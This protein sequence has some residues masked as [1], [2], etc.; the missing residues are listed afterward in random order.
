MLT[1][2][3]I[4]TFRDVY[5]NQ[6]VP[7]NGTEKISDS[8][9]RKIT[10]F[11]ENS[12]FPC[13]DQKAVLLK[14]E[15]LKKRIRHI[16]TSSNNINLEYQVVLSDFDRNCTALSASVKHVKTTSIIAKRQIADHLQRPEFQWY[17]SSPSEIR[18]V[19]KQNPRDPVGFLEKGILQREQILSETSFPEN[20]PPERLLKRAVLRYPNQSLAYLDEV[21][22]TGDTLLRLD[23]FSFFKKKPYIV[24]EAVAFSTN[25]PEKRLKS[26]LSRYEIITAWEHKKMFDDAEIAHV[27]SCTKKNPIDFLSQVLHAEQTLIAQNKYPSFKESSWIIRH[28]LIFHSD[29]PEAFLDTVILTIKRL[30]EVFKDS[31]IADQF[32]FFKRAAVYYHRN[33]DLFLLGLTASY[34]EILSKNEYELFHDQRPSLLHLCEHAPV[35][36]IERMNQAVLLYDQHSH[37]PRITSQKN[38]MSKLKRLCLIR[39]NE[40]EKFF[41][42]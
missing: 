31:I 11:L 1:C 14:Y 37:D 39:P 13:E 27:V 29:A 10:L 28:A 16:F 22:S 41:K 20:F 8:T 12:G 24:Y 30:R 19:T 33:P 18:D 5:S 40:I 9:T 35:K 2:P 3:S 32:G 26:L 15:I 25:S 17:L 38:W 42:I 34:Q 23:E 36:Y 6:D 4:E 7:L 21:K